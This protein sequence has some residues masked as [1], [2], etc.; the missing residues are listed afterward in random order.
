[1]T[2]QACRIQNG[3]ACWKPWPKYVFS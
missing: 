3:L 2:Y 1:M